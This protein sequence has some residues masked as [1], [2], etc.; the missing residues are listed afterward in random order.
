MVSRLDR[1]KLIEYRDKIT[2]K[3]DFEI[4]ICMDFDYNFLDIKTLIKSNFKSLKDT[5]NWLNKFELNFTNSILPNFKKI[6]IDN[7]IYTYDKKCNIN[8]FKICN[9]IYETSF[10]N[11]GKI[12]LPHKSNCN[13]KSESVVYT[14][15]P[16]NL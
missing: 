9:F 8:N 13:C 10:I 16:T 5:F 2:S 14:A 4:R 12:Y 7:C 3:N 15:C 1:S 6:L 11:L